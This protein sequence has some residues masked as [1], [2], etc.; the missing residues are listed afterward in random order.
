MGEDAR[1]WRKLMVNSLWILL[2]AITLVCVAPVA[3]IA[4]LI[5]LLL[6]A[7]AI[8]MLYVVRGRL[9]QVTHR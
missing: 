3:A 4:M 7:W 5:I 9:P 1:I 8:T 2:L 6:A